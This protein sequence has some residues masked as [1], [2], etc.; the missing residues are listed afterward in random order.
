[1]HPNTYKIRLLFIHKDLNFTDV[2]TQLSSISGIHFGRSMNAGEDQCLISGEKGEG[3][4][5]DSR[6]GFDFETA[7][8]WSKSEEKDSRDAVDEILE[9][10]R[11]H[12]NLLSELVGKDCSLSIIVSVGVEST[13]SVNVDPELAG[14]LCDFKINLSYDLY[15]PDRLG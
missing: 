6:L 9:K 1:M 11:P 10:L 14:K 7:E 12:K 15:P 4:Y 8:A 5:Y 13:T 2:R 3:K